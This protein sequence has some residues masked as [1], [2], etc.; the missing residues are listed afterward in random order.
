MA[1]RIGIQALAST[2]T[3]THMH[4]RTAAANGQPFYLGSVDY[5]STKQCTAFARAMVEKY[6]SLRVDDAPA[7]SQDGIVAALQTLALAIQDIHDR[8]GSA[9]KSTGGTENAGSDAST[10]ITRPQVV[11]SNDLGPTITAICAALRVTQAANDVPLL[12]SSSGTLGTISGEPGARMFRPLSSASM[13]SVIAE[14]IELMRSGEADEGNSLVPTKL[15]RHDIDQLI[16][17]VLRRPELLPAAHLTGIVRVPFL[18]ETGRLVT[19]NGYDA[20]SGRYLDAGEDLAD[21]AISDAPTPSDRDAASAQLL[22]IADEF[23]WADDA[24]RANYLGALLTP[25]ILPCLPGHA[26]V[27]HLLVDKPAPGSG[28]TYSLQTIGAIYEG[29]VPSVDRASRMDNIEEWEKSILGVLKKRSSI[30]IFDNIEEPIGNQVLF[31]LA[32]TRRYSGRM[33]GHNDV[34]SF[35]VDTLVCYSGNNIRPVDDMLRRIFMARID[36][37]LEH[38]E[39]RVFAHDLLANVARDRRQIITAILTLIR[40]YFV[41]GCPKGQVAPFASYDLWAQAVGGMLTL[42]G[43]HGFLTNRGAIRTSADEEGAAW[44]TFLKV[45]KAWQPEDGFKTS[46][47]LED[48]RNQFDKRLQGYNWATS[49]LEDAAP[50]ALRALSGQKNL[51][52]AL[53]VALCGRVDRPQSEL[54]LKRISKHGGSPT[55]LVTVCARPSGDGGDGPSE[56]GDGRESVSTR[57]NGDGGDG[58]DGFSYPRVQ[59]EETL[60]TTNVE[61]TESDAYIQVQAETVTTVTMATPPEENAGDGCDQT[62]TISPQTVTKANPVPIFASRPEWPCPDCGRH[63]WSDLNSA[64]WWCSNCGSPIGV[65]PS[66]RDWPG[67]DVDRATFHAWAVQERKKLEVRQ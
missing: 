54:V 27:P 22:Y 8:P 65:V 21:L 17:T 56:N 59:E 67:G 5:L 29:G 10:A 61:I 38:P 64:Y 51:L 25:A 3:G 31:A 11:I 23:S 42:A 33:L 18:T 34:L 62:V 45:I 66:P 35:S 58:G 14:S 55:Y 53:G 39:D 47:L 52:K 41:A 30:V 9:R 49:E 50:I 13:G 36:T 15:T 12:F 16:E 4:V 20:Q 1:R 43:I 26:C 44:A 40:A 19:K 6:E 63:M 60:F 48:V 7:L 2:L 57:V 24:S 28:A 32:T 46:A 37:G